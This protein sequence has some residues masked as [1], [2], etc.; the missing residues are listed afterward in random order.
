VLIIDAD[1]VVSQN[2]GLELLSLST[3][4]FETALFLILCFQNLSR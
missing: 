4:H 2:L 3:D 1:E